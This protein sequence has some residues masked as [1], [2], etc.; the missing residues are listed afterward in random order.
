SRGKWNSTSRRGKYLDPRPSTPLRTGFSGG[1]SF[2]KAAPFRHSRESGNPGGYVK[3]KRQVAI[4]FADSFV[5]LCSVRPP[6]VG[7]DAER[8]QDDVGHAQ[9]RGA[10][11]DNS[12]ALD[13]VETFQLGHGRSRDYGGK[14]IFQHLQQIFLL[15]FRDRR[16]GIRATLI[17]KPGRDKPGRAFLD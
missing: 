8:L 17:K 7:E 16:R 5:G 15:I 13:R 4:T 3:R 2:M 12:C 6:R 1:D 11:E 14:E 9:N 10:A